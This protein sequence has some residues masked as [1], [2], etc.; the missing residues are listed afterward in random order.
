MYILLSNKFMLLIIYLIFMLF[1]I[2]VSI[3]TFIYLITPLDYKIVYYKYLYHPILIPLS[4]SFILFLSNIGLLQYQSST[5]TNQIFL[6]IKRPQ[7]V[8]NFII[9]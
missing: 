1:E 7:N 5:K 2:N 9:K 8:P 4:S 3:F 6:N